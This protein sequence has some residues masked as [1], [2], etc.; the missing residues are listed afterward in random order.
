M[1][2]RST[3]YLFFIAILCL[4]PL[5]RE[6]LFGLVSPH[7]HPFATTEDIVHTIIEIVAMALLGGVLILIDRR[8]TRDK[9]KELRVT[10]AVAI[11]TLASLAEYRDAETS[12]HLQRISIFVKI[13][14]DNLQKDSPYS[15]YIKSQNNYIEDLVN[16]S[17]LHDIGKIGVPDAILLKPGALTD[18]E[19]EIIKTHTTI[20]SDILRSA[21]LQFQKRI[22]TQSYLALAF[23]IARGHHEK[24]DGSGYPDSLEGENIPLGSRIVALC[25]VYDA[26]TSDR[27]YKKAWSHEK[28][29]QM[30]K[31][32]RGSHFD[33]I[34]T[35]AFLQ[36]A[37]L[38]E[39][40]KKNYIG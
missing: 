28:A 35:D 37:Q 33:P 13:L 11:E 1:T 31:E 16:A 36:E 38:F 27:V 20:G 19:F 18:E 40:T 2:N 39:I 15:C 7:H 6:F 12:Q 26:V 25:D 4:A 29:V 32:N 14:G 22:G 21:D 24:W 8:F 10:Q 9:S 30:I 5:I 17:V 23:S 34:I 3:N